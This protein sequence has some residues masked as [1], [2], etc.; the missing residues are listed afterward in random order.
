MTTLDERERAFEA[1][2]AHD[3][4]LHPLVGAIL[5]RP[6]GAMWLILLRRK[7]MPFRRNPF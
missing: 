5:I 1:M 6:S 3:E 4:Q 7:Q 2:F